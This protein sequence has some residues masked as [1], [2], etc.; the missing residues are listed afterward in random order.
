MPFSIGFI[1]QVVS[2]IL[3]LLVAD[4]VNG[5]VHLYMDTEDAYGSIAGPLIANF[6]LHHKFPRY[7]EHSLISV[8]FNESGSKVWLV[9]YLIL[10]RLDN[11][12]YAFLNGI[13]DP[14][15]NLIAQKISN[16]YKNST[17]LHFALYVSGNRGIG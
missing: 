3:A 7:V 12:N 1:W 4:F 11:T 16:G 9:G 6:H 15:V 13:T 5:L 10:D 2:L 17:D 14:L 8:Y